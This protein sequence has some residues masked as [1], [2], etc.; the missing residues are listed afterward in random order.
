MKKLVLAFAVLLLFLVSYVYLTLP[1]VSD[2][3]RENPKQTA[4]MQQRAQEAQTAGRKLKKNQIWVPYHSI[5]SYLKSA[6]LI[7]EDDAFFQHGGYDLEQI[8]ESFIKNWEKKSW[9][10]GGSTITQQLAK[11][12]YLSTSKNPLRKLY[13][14][15]L[16]RKSSAS[17]RGM[18]MRPRRSDQS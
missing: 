13:S 8:T 15:I 9:V 14:R 16:Q 12:L 11:N 6:I 7:G 2:L 10:R 3:K 5:S 18:R 1:D 4:L 17:T